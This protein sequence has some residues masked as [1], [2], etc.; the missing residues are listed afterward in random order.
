MDGG[1][2]V[3]GTPLHGALNT[4]PAPEARTEWTYK[5]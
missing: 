3:V 1:L 5:G 4:L 2:T